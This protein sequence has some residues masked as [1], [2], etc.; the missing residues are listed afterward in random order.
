MEE[1]AR[2]IAFMTGNAAEG[3]Q[4]AVRFGIIPN[5]PIA[6]TAI[7]RTHM[8]FITGEAMRRNLMGFYRVLYDANPATLGGKMPDEDFFFMP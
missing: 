7:P 4:L 2:S 5:A 8:V 1:Y 6:E 3:A